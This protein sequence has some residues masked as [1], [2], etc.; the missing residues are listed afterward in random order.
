MY[1]I[2]HDDI[3]LCN[4]DLFDS[5]FLFIFFKFLIDVCVKIK[6]RFQFYFN[7]LPCK[8]KNCYVLLLVYLKTWNAILSIT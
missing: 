1:R 5:T 6:N 8:I 7:F 2:Y 4:T 3:I